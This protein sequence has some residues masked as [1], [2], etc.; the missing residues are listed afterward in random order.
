M[1]SSELCLVRWPNVPLDEWLKLAT[2][3]DPEGGLP[4]DEGM[5]Y[6]PRPAAELEKMDAYLNRLLKS[7]GVSRDEL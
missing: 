5:K 1:H 3:G 6:E 2:E 7:K 4:C